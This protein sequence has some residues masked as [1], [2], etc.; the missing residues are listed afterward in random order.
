MNFMYTL[1]A[2]TIL[3]TAQCILYM[4]KVL[5]T[6][7]CTIY[8]TFVV[9]C[10]LNPLDLLSFSIANNFL[11]IRALYCDKPYYPNLYPNIYPNIEKKYTFVAI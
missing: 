10:L 11:S 7:H 4:R 1:Y 8:S 5:Y 9:D 3:Y 2:Y 6:V